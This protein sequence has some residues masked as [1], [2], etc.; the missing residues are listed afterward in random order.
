[1]SITG[2][3]TSPSGA[4]CVVPSGGVPPYTVEWLTPNLGFG[5]CKTGLTAGN[6][7]IKLTDSSSPVNQTNYIRKTTT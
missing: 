7:S 5:L 6:Y 4:I 1:L 2:T 3:C